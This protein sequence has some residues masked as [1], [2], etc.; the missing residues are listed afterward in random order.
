MWS[1]FGWCPRVIQFALGSFMLTVHINA[2]YIESAHG[3]EEHA[4]LIIN[5]I[6]LKISHLFAFT[7][8]NR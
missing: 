8:S 3:K 4:T 2:L 5:T 1:S 6:P 7:V